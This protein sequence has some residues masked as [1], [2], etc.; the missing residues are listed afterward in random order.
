MHISGI[1]AEMFPI[2]TT[3]T[4][5]GHVRDSSARRVCLL[6]AWLGRMKL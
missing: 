2:S 4:V 3:V 1:D 6:G 5:C